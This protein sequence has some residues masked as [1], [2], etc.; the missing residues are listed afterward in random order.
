MNYSEDQ[1]MQRWAA[2]IGRNRAIGAFYTY[3]DDLSQVALL[4]LI[5]AARHPRAPVDLLEFRKF[6]SQVICTDIIDWKR[7][8]SHRCKPDRAKVVF[9]DSEAFESYRD[10]ASPDS[11]VEWRDFCEYLRKFLTPRQRTVFDLVHLEGWL[12]K[13]VA[14]MLGITPNCV[15]IH[16][17][18]VREK[19][20]I[21]LS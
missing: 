1:E 3:K 12:V 11:L 7:K 5:T 18:L 15:S 9:M 4:G 16:N 20:E 19:L 6:A 17:M 14:E 21:L 10:H 8:I 2:K 13:D